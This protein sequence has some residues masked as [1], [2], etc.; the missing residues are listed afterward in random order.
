MFLLLLHCLLACCVIYFCVFN[1]ILIQSEVLARAGWDPS[2][3]AVGGNIAALGRF[4]SSTA[5][6]ASNQ[7]QPE[8]QSQSQTQTE[9]RAVTI[10][11]Q[12]EK[13]AGAIGGSDERILS[14]SSDAHYNNIDNS[15]S[16]CT[17]E[18]DVIDDDEGDEADHDIDSPDPSDVRISI[19]QVS[20]YSYSFHFLNLLI[21]SL[22]YFLILSIINHFN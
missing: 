18:D 6:A 14:R 17:E 13:G 7:S 21:E 8:S 16:G 10:K 3:T 2:C 15:D 22:N 5:S 20:P 12:N 19:D 1:L 9:A 4:Q 11:Q